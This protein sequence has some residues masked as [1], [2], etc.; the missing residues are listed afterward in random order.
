MVDSQHIDA[1]AVVGD[2]VAIS[3]FIHMSKEATVFSEGL[4]GSAVPSSNVA[5]SSDVWEIGQRP[6]GFVPFG[7]QAMGPVRASD[8]G[9]RASLV[10]VGAVVRNGGCK[11]SGNKNGEGSDRELHCGS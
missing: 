3:A 6:K 4:T 11:S 2:F 1:L 9:Q 8:C 5:A 7:K 10:V